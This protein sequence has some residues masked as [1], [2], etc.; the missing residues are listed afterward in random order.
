MSQRRLLLFANL[1]FASFLTNCSGSVLFPTPVAPHVEEKPST[2]ATTPQVAPSRGMSFIR[3]PDPSIKADE[4]SDILFT[5]QARDAFAA[6][7]AGDRF[8]IQMVMEEA[9]APDQV[10]LE[11]YAK[12]RFS[13]FQKDA[14]GKRLVS[15]DFESEGVVTLRNVGS[16]DTMNAV[17]K[18]RDGKGTRVS[19]SAQRSSSPDANSASQNPWRGTLNVVRDSKEV[20]FG[21]IEGFSD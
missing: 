14:S 17:F 6:N 4:V 8:E 21:R 18:D 5:G 3:D 7:A 12:I 19:I 16:S 11:S 1:V 2:P 10:N 20:P 9:K 15:R 13:I